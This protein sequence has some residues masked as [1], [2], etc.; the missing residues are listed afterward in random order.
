VKPIADCDEKP[1]VK[2]ILKASTADYIVDRKSIKSSTGGNA[3]PWSDSDLVSA[4]GKQAKKDIER[5]AT[6]GLVLVECPGKDCFCHYGPEPDKWTPEKKP[7][8]GED[9][10][11][12]VESGFVMKGGNVERKMTFKYDLLAQWKRI[13]GRCRAKA[14]KMPPPP[15][16]PDDDGPR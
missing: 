4:A 11:I 7:V 2:Y 16:S 3:G 9:R 6:D 14:F 5:L 15:T 13:E 1:C 12:E 8:P 10:D